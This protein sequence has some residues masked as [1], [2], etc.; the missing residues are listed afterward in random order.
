MDHTTV[1]EEVEN[2]HIHKETWLIRDFEGFGVWK[3]IRPSNEP[4]K[5][6]RFWGF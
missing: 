1:I 5:R 6:G 3:L 4:G 2:L